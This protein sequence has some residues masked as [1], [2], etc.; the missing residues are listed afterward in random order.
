VSSTPLALRGSAPVGVAARIFSSLHRRNYRLWF[1]GQTVSQSGTWM[2]SVAQASLVRWTLHGSAVDLG[3]TAALQ[4]GPVLVLG[5]V[6]G[7]LADRFDKRKVLLATQTAFTIQALTL[8]LLVMTGVA[9]LWMVWALALLMGVINAAD[10]PSRQSFVAEMVGPDDLTN[11][12]GL[13]SVIVNAS[14]IAGPGLAG[15]L[16]LT[17]GLPWTFMVNAASFGAVIAA[18]AAMR[19]YDLHRRPPIARGKGQLRAGLHYAWSAWELRVPLVMLA[20]VGTLAYN[21]SVVLPLFADAFHGNKGTLS[22]MMTAMGV[23]ALV[24]ALAAAARRRPSYRFLVVIAGVFGLFLAAVA[25]SPS[26]PVMLLLL[27][28]MGAA[29]ILFISTVNSLLQLYSSDAM[30]GRVMAL[31]AMVFLGSTP[32]GGPLTGLIAAH[33]GVRVALGVGAAATLAVSAGGAVALRRIRDER[34]AAAVQAPGSG[35]E[36]ASALPADDG[37]RA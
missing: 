3:I 32:I 28:P 8:G 17:V 30:R 6:G 26:L 4:F 25:A 36:P 10:S 23:G 24:G 37:A 21:F 1:F 13:N 20:V 7:L 22:V 29:S 2:Q 18:L 35:A 14:R 9:Q 27:V 31:W 19:P 15:I 11:A 12:V 16:M 5:P 33:G 34:R